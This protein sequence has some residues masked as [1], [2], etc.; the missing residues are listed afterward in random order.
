MHDLCVKDN[1]S[2]DGMQEGQ[3]SDDEMHDDMQEGQPSDDDMQERLPQEA[4]AS[5][6]DMTRWFTV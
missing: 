5:D 4:E 1:S 6:L 3:P 2:D